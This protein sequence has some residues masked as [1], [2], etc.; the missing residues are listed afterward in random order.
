MNWSWPTYAL[1]I[2]LLLWL[3]LPFLVLEIPSTATLTGVL[4][5][6]EG[7]AGTAFGT[8]LVG[9]LGLFY[10]SNRPLGLLVGTAL[11]GIAIGIEASE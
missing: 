9:S 10:K 11:A 8:L 6:T 1:V 5:V 2:G 3:I 4:H 7:R